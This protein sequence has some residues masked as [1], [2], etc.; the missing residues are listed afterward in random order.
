MEAAATSRSTQSSICPLSLLHSSVSTAR[1]RNG[2]ILLLVQRGCETRQTNCQAESVR[3]FYLSAAVSLDSAAARVSLIL[4]PSSSLSPTSSA[5][6]SARLLLDSAAA[7]ASSNSV[8]RRCSRALSSLV[9]SFSCL[10]RRTGNLSYSAKA[11]QVRGCRAQHKEEN[12]EVRGERESCFFLS[13]AGL[14][15]A[16]TLQSYRASVP[17][18][19]VQF[20]AAAFMHPLALLQSFYFRGKRRLFC[21]PL[22]GRLVCGISRSP[23]G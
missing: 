5:E 15:A 14:F 7:F 13:M 19:G 20:F 17:V 22:F 3:L 10:G 18:C 1:T 12:L 16:S 8:D 11:S 21:L 2:V 4:R 23:V 6:A 9:F